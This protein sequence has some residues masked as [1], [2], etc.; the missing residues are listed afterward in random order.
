MKYE[1]QFSRRKIKRPIFRKP[2]NNKRENGEM[3]RRFR[4]WLDVQNYAPSTMDGYGRVVGELC[5]F[6][7]NKTVRDVTPMDI[8]D[9][10]TQVLP[11]K[12]SDCHVVHRLGALRSF[13]DFLYLGGVVDSVAPRFLRARTR[14]KKLPRTVTQSQAKKLIAAARNSRDRALLELFYGTG[15]RVGEVSRMRVEQIDFVRRTIR[16]KAKRKERTAYFGVPAARA[17]RRYLGGRRTGY[18]FQDIIRPQRGYITFYKRAWLGCWRDFRPG[19]GYGRRHC[20]FLGNPATTSERAAQLKFKRFL[21]SVDLTRAKPDKPLTRSTLGKIVQEIGR[22]IGI[23]ASPHVLR[24]SFATHLLER[25]ADIR[26]IQELMGHSYL[27]ST[28]IYTRISNNAVAS[29]FRK[30]HPRSA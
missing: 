28:Q 29:A 23:Q 26:A 15:C 8:G 24:H 9:F 14:E 11:E 22:R 20:K 10:L 3:A 27:T 18:V 25:G 7:G 19:E 17:L 2:L 16:V 1:G 4:R 5:R 30:F 13:F 12:R 6:L 21:Q